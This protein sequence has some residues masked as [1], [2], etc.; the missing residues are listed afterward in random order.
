MR[1]HQIDGGHDHAGGTE[2]ALQG[3]MLAEHLLHRMQGAVGRGE[4][5]DRQDAGAV[6]LQRKLGA[7]FHR[8]PVDMHHAGAALAGVAADMGAG[9]TEL[10]TQ[11]FDKQG[12]SFDLY[13]MLLAV[14]RQGYLRHRAPFRCSLSDTS[15][16]QR[17]QPTRGLCPWTVPLAGVW[18]FR[19]VP[20]KPGVRIKRAGHVAAAVTSSIARPA[21]STRPRARRASGAPTAPGRP[22]ARRP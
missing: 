14:D 22:H 21:P 15:G 5:L 18:S 13:R 3:V 11:Q 19:A 8:D 6:R 17:L 12:A 4:A 10:L 7:G 9:E 1:L 16:R 2:A 20:V